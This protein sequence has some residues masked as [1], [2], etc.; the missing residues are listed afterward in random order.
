[1]QPIIQSTSQHRAPAPRRRRGVT[2]VMAM[3]FMILFSALAIGFFGAVTMSTQIAANEQ[4]GSRAMLAAESGM[5][6]MKYQLATLGIEPNTPPEQLFTKVYERLGVKLNNRPNMPAGGQTVTLDADGD[7]IYVPGGGNTWIPLETSTGG[8]PMFRAE[9]TKLLAG[10]ELEVKV[11]GRYGNGSAS[12]GGTRAVKLNYANL[13]N[14]AE[15]FSYGLASK[16]KIDMKGNVTIRG[17]SGN[18]SMGSVLSAHSATNVPLTMTGTPVISGHV[19]FVNANAQPSISANSTIADLSPGEAGFDDVIH[20][21]VPEPE[22]PLINTSAFAAFVPSAT[23]PAGPQ[24]IT[25]KTPSGTS[26]TN[27]RIKANTNPTF[28]DNT[29]INGVVYIESPNNVK[30]GGGAKI[31]GVIVTATDA[32]NNDGHSLTANVVEFRGGVMFRPV[33]DTMPE[34]L[35]RLTGSAMLVPGFTA[36]FGGNFD[37]I[38][39]TIVAS[40]MSFEGTAGGTIKGSV[41]NLK[42]SGV[43]LAG[44]TDIII[45]SQGTAN[46]PA[47][48]FFGTHY[49]AL[50]YT[51]EEVRP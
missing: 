37:T 2:A 51:Y 12:T 36:I 14:P 9:V 20:K 48:I 28:N 17:T 43:S 42:D 33:P 19:S 22:F 38:N 26:F 47:G 46:H 25:S 50:P 8:G 6:F 21:G 4:R 1:M 7:V 16:S 24:V 40:Q 27:I 35:R 34:A 10:E 39:G 45:E 44:T 41:I 30:F 13:P 11:F 5:Q 29:V 49:S 23:A 32:N 18:E 31:N 3:L 15:I